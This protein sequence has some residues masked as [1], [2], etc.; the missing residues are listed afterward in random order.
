MNDARNRQPP[1]GP[2]PGQEPRSIE[3]KIERLRQRLRDAP[4]VD[5]NM[6]AIFAGMLDLLADEL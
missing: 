6:R 3:A 1:R 5:A 2:Q 4:N